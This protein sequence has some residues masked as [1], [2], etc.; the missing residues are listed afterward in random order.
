MLSLSVSAQTP[1]IPEGGKKWDGRLDALVAG[2]TVQRI[3]AK[4]VQ[5]VTPQTLTGVII[6]SSEPAVTADFV[7]EQGFEAM[8]ITD[9]VLT[10]TIPATLIPVLAE[11]EE[12]LYINSTRTYEPFMDKVRPQVGATKVH[13][14][15]GLETPFTGKGVVVRLQEC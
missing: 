9:R 8:P 14:G 10:A 13:A 7:K 1:F 11:R 12:V 4:G 2:G 15:T 5:S 6:N 3:A